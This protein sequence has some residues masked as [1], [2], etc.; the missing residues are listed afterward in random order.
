LSLSNQKIF[1]ENLIMDEPDVPAPL[2]HHQAPQVI[3]QH[4]LSL[5][6]PIAYMQYCTHGGTERPRWLQMVVYSEMEFLVTSLTKDSRLLLH[7]IHS[8]FYWWIL[9]KT[10][11]FTGLKN[12]YKINLQNKKT[13]SIHE[14][15]FVERK[16]VGRKSDKT[17]LWED[18]SLCPKTSTKNTVQEFHLWSGSG[19]I[20]WTVPHFK[21]IVQPKKRGV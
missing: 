7:A 16:N 9:Q 21:D 4:T 17:R 1:F 18:L 5:P 14:K 2:L 19:K 13:Q 12:P 11:L 20:E 15:H 6:T 10:I 8:P 3:A